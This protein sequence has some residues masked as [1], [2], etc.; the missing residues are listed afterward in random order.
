MKLRRTQKCARFL[1]HPVCVYASWKARL[2]E[3][4]YNVITIASESATVKRNN[5][6]IS[7]CYLFTRA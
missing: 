4:R 7:L 3:V 2:P 1:I 5:G 6:P